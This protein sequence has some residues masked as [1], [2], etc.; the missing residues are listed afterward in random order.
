[1]S[2]TFLIGDWIVDPDSG[3]LLHNGVEVRL[4]PKVMAVLVCLAQHAGK[5]VSREMLE[6]SV[7]AGMV[8]GYDAISASIIKLRKAFGDDSR[9]PRY[10]ETVSKKGYRLIAPVRRDTGADTTL[11]ASP[12]SQADSDNPF[13]RKAPVLKNILSNRQILA[14]TAFLAGIL[15]MWNHLAQ[16]HQGIGSRGKNPSV[17]VLPFKNLNHDPGQDY[18][19][20]GITDDL[21]TD[22][23]K[24]GTLRVIARQ[25]AY[26]FK[27]KES[28]SPTEIGQDLAV[29]YIIQGSVQKAKD[30]IRINVQLT[31]VANGQVIWAERFDSTP[32]DLFDIQDKITREVT[33]AMATT[34]SGREIKI[35]KAHKPGSFK[36]YDAFLL[37][38]KYIGQR[39]REGYEMALTAYKQAVELDPGFARAYGAMA[40][41]LTHGYRFQW[42]ELS[43]GEARERAL[44]LANKAVVMDQTS[45]QIYWALGYVHL[46]RKEFEAAE[47][48]AKKAIELSPSYAD[49]YGLLAYISNWRG[50][51]TQA[52]TYINKASALNPYHSFD[53][54]WNLGLAYYGQGRYK[55]AVKSLKDALERNENALYPRLFLTASYAR[56][57]QMQDAAWEIE[58]IKV[59]R[60]DT[61]L[62]HLRH[63]MPFEHK[64][65]L[66]SVLDDLRKAGL[67]E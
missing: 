6:S 8:V 35:N 26:H 41:A 37:G 50:K 57:G 9:R 14:S 4:E 53:Y 67:A 33:A 20:D 29:Q 47:T 12:H 27:T 62:S 11:P 15:L 58:N 3:R 60:P 61:T 5:V 38:Q 64:N 55:E 65:N 1:M 40:V 49:G 7:W 17:A 21:T 16:Q 25:S 13:D 18:F 42:T 45:P 43:L 56:L 44:K 51:F 28:I 52:E 30:R 22:L 39:S 66:H 54:P 34:V 48:A 31:R 59:S 24:T 63:I 2:D 32:D 19:S 23:S 36:A 10:I 46:H